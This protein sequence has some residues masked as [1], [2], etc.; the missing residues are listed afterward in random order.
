[1]LKS[2]SQ[3][4]KRYPSR[5]R[6]NVLIC[7]FCGEYCSVSGSLESIHFFQV[8]EEDHPSYEHLDRS[9]SGETLLDSDQGGNPEPQDP[10]V[11]MRTSSIVR[12]RTKPKFPWRTI[13]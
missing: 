3:I 7:P 4:H 5:S 6:D 1:M 10:K 11:Y 12:L 8:I 9:D 13:E 2:D